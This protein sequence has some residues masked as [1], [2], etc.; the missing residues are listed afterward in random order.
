MRLEW[1]WRGAETAA[2]RG[3]LLVVVDVLSFSTTAVTALANG[4]ILYPCRS[5]AEAHAVAELTG[6]ALAVKRSA[7]DEMTEGFSLSPC[8]FLREGNGVSVALPSPNGATCCR[9]GASAPHLLIGSLLNARAVAD[10]ASLWAEQTKGA[11]TVL[12]CGERW[13]TPHEDGTLRF[14][15]EDYLGA[16]AIFS[17]LSPALSRSPEAQAAEEVFLTSV[18]RLEE[19]LLRC[20]SGQELT[21]RGYRSDVLHAAQW[22]RY[23]IVPHLRENLR[24]EPLN[25]PLTSS[26]V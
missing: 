26:A 12:A 20:G 8:S 18:P 11:I 13:A 7:G 4:F 22:N 16:G 1:G 25:A 19:T 21:D 2:A 17:A 15:L 10:A 3:D 14:A 6:A 24:L 9:L 5:D 23:T